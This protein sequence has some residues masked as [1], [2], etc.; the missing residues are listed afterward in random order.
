LII[1]ELVSNSLKH[2]F[3]DGRG[4]EVRVEFG[5][6]EGGRYRLVVSDDGVSMPEEIDLRNTRSLG[7]QLV[8]SLVDQLDGTIELDRNGGLTYNIVFGAPAS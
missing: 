6:G 5:V 7:L 2:A 8:G 1:N 3:V 4:G